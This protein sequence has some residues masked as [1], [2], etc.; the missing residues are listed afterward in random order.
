MNIAIVE[1]FGGSE[2]WHR[3]S[4][5]AFSA[6]VQQLSGSKFL[7]RCLVALPIISYPAQSGVAQPGS[8]E[9][10]ELLG[11]FAGEWREYQGTYEHQ[12]AV[13]RWEPSDQAELSQRLYLAQ[14]RYQEGAKLSCEIADGRI[15]YKDL[16]NQEQRLVEEYDTC[17]SAKSLE[18]VLAEHAARAPKHRGAGVVL[19]IPAPP[20]VEQPDL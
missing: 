11:Q 8:S 13:K 20:R 10:L 19:E 1:I 7:L 3:I 4:E 12:E 9:M 5:M 16:D 18:A 15:D 6:Y 17:V 2:D 14:N